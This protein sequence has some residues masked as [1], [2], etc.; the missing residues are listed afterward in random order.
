MRLSD[1]PC[2]IQ[3]LAN[4]SVC[5]VL[6]L[7]FNS[8]WARSKMLKLKS[9]NA[10]Q[11]QLNGHCNVKLWLWHSCKPALWGLH[12]ECLGHAK[13]CWV[14]QPVAAAQWQ[15]HRSAPGQEKPQSWLEEV[16]PR[17]P[18]GVTQASELQ[19]L[20]PSLLQVQSADRFLS[21]KLK[22]GKQPPSHQLLQESC[23]RQ[24][25]DGSKEA[26]SNS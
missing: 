20:P 21:C 3:D 10:L 2:V 19:A 14:L 9:S 12:V 23:R 18:A 22:E 11:L 16:W 17:A 4:C 8:R 1:H 13:H 26:K 25:Y 24:G 7:K 5:Q 6:K 15:T